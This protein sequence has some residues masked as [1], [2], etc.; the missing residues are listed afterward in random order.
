[1]KNI[2]GLS[3]GTELRKTIDNIRIYLDG[4]ADT[5]RDL[6]GAGNRSLKEARMIARFL[7]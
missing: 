7:A 5:I 6:L 2:S 4:K 3:D 1:M